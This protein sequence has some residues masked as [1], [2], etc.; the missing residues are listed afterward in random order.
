MLNESGYNWSASM[1]TFESAFNSD[2]KSVDKFQRKKVHACNQKAKGWLFENQI[3][4]KFWA[5]ILFLEEG[6]AEIN[7]ESTVEEATPECLFL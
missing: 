4:V 7:T 2:S 5:L 3:F 6:A 1:V